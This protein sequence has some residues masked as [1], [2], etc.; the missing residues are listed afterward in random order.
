M[1]K[2]VSQPVRFQGRPLRARRAAYYIVDDRN[3]MR[4][5]GNQKWVDSGFLSKTQ[6]DAALAAR[7]DALGTACS[8][9]GAFM[10]QLMA[11]AMQAAGLGGWVYGGFFL[12]RRARRNA[13]L[14]RARLPLRAVGIR[15]RFPGPVGRDGVFEAFC[16]PYYPDMD[17]AVDAA[18]EGATMS[19][20]GLGGARDAQAAHRAERGIRRGHG[21]GLAR[22]ACSA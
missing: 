2:L 8:P 12:A 5:C 16:P 20:D 13:D 17:A 19:M 21:A 4:P 22:G 9:R 15:P 10:G 18:I 6:G 1:I 14:P 7:E 3:G 11:L